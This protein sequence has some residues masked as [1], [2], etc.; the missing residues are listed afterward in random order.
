MNSSTRLQPSVDLAQQH[1]DDAARKVAECQQ[2]VKDRKLQLDELVGYRGEYTDGLLQK[3]RAGLHSARMNDY[4]L[5]MERLNNAI[6]QL[7]VAL[8][9]AYKELAT[10]K[11]TL[12]EKLQRLKVLENV[13]MRHQQ[14]ERQVQSRREQNESDDHAQRVARRVF[15]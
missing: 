4:S 12:L 10:S 2:A 11:R 8:E 6:E 3:S 9:S 5:F 15:S 1:A 7:Q 14:S 13:V